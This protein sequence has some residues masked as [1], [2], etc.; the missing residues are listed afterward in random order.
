[1]NKLLVSLFART[2]LA[3]YSPNR[4]KH[5]PAPDFSSALIQSWLETYLP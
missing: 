2:D 1:M 3:L 4:A 5:A